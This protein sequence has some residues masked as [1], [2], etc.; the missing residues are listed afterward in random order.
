MAPVD[1]PVSNSNLTVTGATGGGATQTAGAASGSAPPMPIAAPPPTALSL[2]LRDLL[3]PA[4]LADIRR[5]EA[6]KAQGGSVQALERAVAAL[7]ARADALD[8]EARAM[9]QSARTPR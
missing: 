9:R 4:T 5:L 3:D 8:A 1:R 6:A 7:R 2:E